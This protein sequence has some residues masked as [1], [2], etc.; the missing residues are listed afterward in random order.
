MRRLIPALTILAA[1][2]LA[3]C[4]DPNVGKSSDSDKP[5]EEKKDP[6]GPNALEKE[7][8]KKVQQDNKQQGK[9]G[10]AP[11]FTTKRVSGKRGLPGLMSDRVY[12]YHQVIKVKPNLRI[13]DKPQ[14]QSVYGN[15]YF[16]LAK[17]SK[18]IFDYQMR[19]SKALNGRWPTY[20]E[21]INMSR[22]MRKD[23]MRLPPFAIYAYDEKT[24]KLHIMEDPE[25]KKRHQEASK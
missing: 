25:A 24:G 19:Q 9:P 12:D 14:G 20:D 13:I 8:D 21:Y 16:T 23:L 1:F 15:A 6:A 5:K 10:A 17:L 22:D 2:A 11:K 7:L 18:G 3:G 4:L